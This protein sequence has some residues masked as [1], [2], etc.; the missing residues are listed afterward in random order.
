MQNHRI[1]PLLSISF[2]AL[3]T[4]SSIL[5]QVIETATITNNYRYSVGGV[6]GSGT[7]NGGRTDIFRSVT[8]GTGVSEMG[9]SLTGTLDQ[10]GS[11]FFLHNGVCVGD[12]FVSMTTN[13]TFS[14][15]NSGTAPI[16]LR[17]DSQITPGHL[18]N[19]F[20]NPVSNA[21]ATFDFMVSQ[22]PGL[23]QGILYEADGDA[24]AIPPVIETSDGSVFNGFTIS[25]NAPDWAVADWSATNL[26]VVLATLAPGQTTNLFYTST[27][28]IGTTQP[29]CPDPTVCESYQVAFGDPRNAGGVLNAASLMSLSEFSAAASP[30]NTALNPAVG[31]QFDPFR[32]TYRF[33]PIT[34]APQDAQPIIPPIT[35]DVN[36]RGL[37]AVPEPATWLFMVLGFGVVSAALRRPRREAPLAIA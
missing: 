19:S 5:A 13:I 24:K 6:A 16:G 22:D 11:F 30:L 27:V 8:T 28:T 32:V 31:A 29:N 36:Y 18:A 17:F 12:C 10:Q 20:L 9:M 37:G 26:S 23:R 35:Y 34:S 33:V 3:A 2:L 14:L 25:N 15:F 21:Q 4:P 1:C 7:D